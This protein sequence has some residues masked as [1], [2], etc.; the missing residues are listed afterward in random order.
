MDKT[1]AEVMATVPDGTA[2]TL[3]IQVGEQVPQP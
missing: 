2:K 1:L 3:G